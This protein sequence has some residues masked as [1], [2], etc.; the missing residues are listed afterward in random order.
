MNTPP[1][2]DL[3]NG[4]QMIRPGQDF[5]NKPEEIAA[6]KQHIDEHATSAEDRAALNQ[7][8]FGGK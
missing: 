3:Q 8:I 7:T 5:S 2:D 1:P 6:V 4:S